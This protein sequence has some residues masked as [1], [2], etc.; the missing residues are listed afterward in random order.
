MEQAKSV[1]AGSGS[2]TFSGDA[3]WDAPEPRSRK[4]ERIELLNAQ[5]E[6]FEAALAERSVH[7]PAAVVFEEAGESLR[8][9]KVGSRWGLYF[10]SKNGGTCAI[11]STSLETR[12]RAAGVLGE[13]Y[14]RVMAAR[15]AIDSRVEEALAKAERAVA[16][17]RGDACAPPTDEELS[18]VLVSAD[19]VEDV[20]CLAREVDVLEDLDALGW[21]GRFSERF[22]AQRYARALGGHWPRGG[23][24]R[25]VVE[26]VVLLRREREAKNKL[27]GE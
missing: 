26:E 14:E 18:A 12:C 4:D 11:L 19:F 1:Y 23:P 24:L 20:R 3:P 5:L 8:Y 15:G 7:A 6:A 21:R 13:L 10:E 17:A 9:G 25:R 16:L 22:A 2:A 27:A